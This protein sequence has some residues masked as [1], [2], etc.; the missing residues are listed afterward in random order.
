MPERWEFEPGQIVGFLPKWRRLCAAA[1]RLA[2]P[3][4]V[5]V[6]NLDGEVIW[7]CA[8]IRGEQGTFKREVPFPERPLRPPLTIV[9]EA[10]N[11]DTVGDTITADDLE[12]PIQ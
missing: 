11:G 10:A 8:V 5:T 12:S 1:S 9:I 6:T 2:D 4:T 7:N 3:L